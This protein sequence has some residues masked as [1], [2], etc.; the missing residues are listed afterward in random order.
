ME[1]S[2]RVKHVESM[3]VHCAS[4]TYI[5][6]ADN[7]MSRNASLCKVYDILKRTGLY[8]IDYITMNM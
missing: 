2:E 3:K 5:K 7:T 6:R 1:I 4:S 8:H